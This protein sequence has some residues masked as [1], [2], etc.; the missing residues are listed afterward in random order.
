MQKLLF[1]PDGP[2]KAQPKGETGSSHF[3]VMETAMGSVV[4]KTVENHVTTDCNRTR[5]RL[6]CGE[7]EQGRRGASMLFSQPGSKRNDGQENV[8]VGVSSHGCLSD[9]QILAI[10]L[11]A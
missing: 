8:T 10:M 4:T 11:E 3:V 7:G 9:S 1:C 6:K 2:H 5:W